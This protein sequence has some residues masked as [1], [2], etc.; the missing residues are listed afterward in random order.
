MA[1]EGIDYIWSYDTIISINT[2]SF[3]CLQME[4]L[5]YVLVTRIVQ[6]SGKGAEENV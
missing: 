2:K 1:G 6:R 5:F 4:W 3:P